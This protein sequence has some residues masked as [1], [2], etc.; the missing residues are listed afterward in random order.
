MPKL[1]TLVCTALF[2]FS[3]LLLVWYLERG[4]LVNGSPNDEEP[5]GAGKLEAPGTYA[6]VLVKGSTLVVWTG[7]SAE[8]CPI[9]L[10]T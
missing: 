7:G 3:I 8:L 2:E 9:R 5:P 6:P 1:P 10:R 4:L